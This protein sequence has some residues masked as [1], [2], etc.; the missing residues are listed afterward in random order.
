MTG[1]GKASGLC[2]LHDGY[3]MD[4][5]RVKKQKLTEQQI[6]KILAQKNITRKDIFVEA[7]KV[8]VA[9]TYY[10]VGKILAEHGINPKV[11]GRTYNKK[12]GIICRKMTNEQELKIVE[13]MSDRPTVVACDV[14]A[15]LDDMNIKLSRQGLSD[16]MRRLGYEV[17]PGK[18]QWHRQN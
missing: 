6:E 16:L 14:V 5:T 10:D 11:I 17:V 15:V 18:K 4:T 1:R 7:E 8:G 2:L 3:V 9:L 13:W 12:S